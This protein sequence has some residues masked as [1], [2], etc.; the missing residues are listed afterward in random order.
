[1]ISDFCL[2]LTNNP[3]VVSVQDIETYKSVVKDE[4]TEWLAALRVH[5][6][7][8]WLIIVV[9]NDESKVKTKLL[10]TSVIDKVKSDFCSKQ[11]ER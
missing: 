11:G 5:N 4:I 9:V 8:D 7:G 2:N 6:I 3:A 1:M 10:R